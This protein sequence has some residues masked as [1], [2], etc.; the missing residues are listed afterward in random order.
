MTQGTGDEEA[1]NGA[2]IKALLRPIAKLM[3]A[4]GVTA[5]RL[6]DLLQEVFV[7]VAEDAFALGGEPPTDSR[8]SLLTGV[9]RKKVRSLRQREAAGEDAVERRVSVMS[10]VIGRWLADPETSDVDGK[11]LPL[12]RHAETGPSFDSLVAAVST[13]V[14]P[15]T[16]LDELLRRGAVRLEGDDSVTL[17]SEAL[18]PRESEAERLHFLARNLTDHLAAAVE[19]VLCESGPPPFLERAVFY[20]NLQ[21]ASV[22]AVEAQARGLSGELLAELNRMGFARQTADREASEPGA[23]SDANHRFRFGV[24]FYRED[25]AA[26]EDE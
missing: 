1:L 8:V 3:I 2:A 26:K 21:A 22:D 18:L 24:F 11:P 13:D 15:R 4:K 6:H 7:E 20:N 16:I 9:H 25:E 12:P 14:R 10:T 19:N 23:A 5:P 17:L